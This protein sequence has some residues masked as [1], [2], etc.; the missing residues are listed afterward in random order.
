MEQVFKDISSLLEG[1][2]KPN[3]NI[4]TKI[5][6]H[7]FDVILTCTSQEEAWEYFSEDLLSNIIKYVGPNSCFNEAIL[8]IFINLFSV[9]CLSTRLS[10]HK[11]L[12]T[13]INL[14]VHSIVDKN[15]LYADK[16][17]MFLSNLTRLEKGCEFVSVNLTP[18]T[19]NLKQLV[20]AFATIGYNSKCSLDQLAMVFCNLSQVGQVRTVITQTENN[21]L[22]NLIPFMNHDNEIRR[23]GITGVVHNCA[24]DSSIHNLLLSDEVDLLPRLLLPLAGPEQFDDEDNDKLPIDLQYLPDTKT[25]EPSPDIRRQLLETLNQLCVTKFGRQFLRDHNTYIILRELHKWEENPSVLLACENVVDILI[26][27]EEE[28]GFDH[29]KTVDIPEELEEKFNN[30]TSNE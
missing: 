24:F 15:C 21:I 7:I 18:L 19:E 20:T 28:I 13:L 11:D 10:T 3:Q 8:K 16:F 26:R 30:L 1:G 17:C 12:V 6:H 25:R 22:Q 9:D 5:T 4:D 2:P 23:S 27:T 29:L 14:S